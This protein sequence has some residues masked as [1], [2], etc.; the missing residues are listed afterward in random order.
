MDFNK[1]LFCPKFNLLSILLSINLLRIDRK[2]WI[3]IE[4]EMSESTDASTALKAQ[5]MRNALAGARARIMAQSFTRWRV[6]ANFLS[7]IA[8]APQ[9]GLKMHLMEYKYKF[10]ALNKKM[11]SY[12]R[13]VNAARS[14]LARQE[15]SMAQERRSLL[16]QIEIAR[17]EGGGAAPDGDDAAS[18]S[19]LNKV[20][21]R[22]LAERT[23][24][25]LFGR[26]HRFGSNRAQIKQSAERVL[27]AM[28]DTN[29]VA[30][31]EEPLPSSP[32]PVQPDSISRNSIGSRPGHGSLRLSSSP[33]VQSNQGGTPTRAVSMR[34]GDLKTASANA[35]P[36]P[37]TASTPSGPSQPQDVE[38]EMEEYIVAQR[39][40]IAYLTLKNALR[41]LAD[42]S[43]VPDVRK[44]F[45]KWMSIS[46]VM[47]KGALASK[48][49]EVDSWKLHYETYEGQMKEH[50]EKTETYTKSLTE[51]LNARTIEYEEAKKQL[52][53]AA[54][55]RDE[56]ASK[57][58]AL[59]QQTASNVETSAANGELENK[60]VE[61]NKALDVERRQSFVSGQSLVEASKA[62]AEEKRRN[63][64][65][66]ELI[67]KL[68]VAI[69]GL[70]SNANA[71][72]D[73]SSSAQTSGDQMLLA[74]DEQF[75]SWMTPNSK[76]S[77]IDSLKL[78]S[79]RPSDAGRKSSTKPKERGRSRSMYVTTKEAEPLFTSSSMRRSSISGSEESGVDKLPPLPPSEPSDFSRASSLSASVDSFDVPG[80]SKQDINSV[81]FNPDIESAM[82]SKILTPN[83]RPAGRRSLLAGT[84]SSSAQSRAAPSTPVAE[85]STPRRSSASAVPLTTPPRSESKPAAL[86][87]QQSKSKVSG[88]APERTRNQGLQTADDFESSL[89]DVW[90][91]ISST[92]VDST[93]MSTNVRVAVRMR[94]LNARETEMGSQRVVSMEGNTVRLIEDMNTGTDHQF[95]YDFCFDASELNESKSTAGAQKMV[96]DRLGME[97]LSHAWSGYNACLFAYGQTGSGKSYS[98]MGN[99][100]DAGIIP[101]VCRALFYMISRQGDSDN[102]SGI[103]PRHISVEADYLEIYNENIRDLLDSTRNNLRVR[104]HPTTGVFVE[105]LSSCAVESY[106]DVE[107]LLAMGLEQRTTA[108]TNMNS[109]SSRSHSVFTISIRSSGYDEN[110][111]LSQK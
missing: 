109:E 7:E 12:E 45:Y 75:Y 51:E 70:G 63:N 14:E 66:A 2:N 105:N 28:D 74:E 8:K 19:W 31:V 24:Q 20:S 53:E 73:A 9:E 36:A 21:E 60:I 47:V 95:S 37:N 102:E 88:T 71:P 49:A 79:L 40:V 82:N 44:A 64:E 26:M 38:I 81:V 11:E 16:E 85:A 48:A 62:L 77:A 80:A 34:G 110:G 1:S 39:N 90:R 96:F 18:L 10:N 89:E 3:D 59:E 72:G 29:A 35:S 25:A 15:I 17:R 91:T 54:S 5:L 50:W 27:A 104:E 97:V 107:D 42:H 100:T 13:E 83:S 55:E 78:L 93:P 41:T 30:V 101:R 69:S 68:T 32:A 58:N 6:T 65:K 106:E 23:R 99:A 76:S 57:L 4:S 86:S 33:S 111:N 46:F 108:A 52:E 22:S 103:E 94:P 87:K 92:K 56:V 98:M 84:E 67:S 61:L 43:S